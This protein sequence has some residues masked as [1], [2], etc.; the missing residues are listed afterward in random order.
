MFARIKH[1]TQRVVD[2]C[3]LCLLLTG[4]IV[5]A[6]DNSYGSR[7]H[8]RDGVYV[9]AEDDGYRT[10]LYKDRRYGYRPEYLDPVYR[11]PTRAPEDRY[12]FDVSQKIIAA[13]KKLFIELKFIHRIGIKIFIYIN[14]SVNFILSFK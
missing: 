5:F 3:C 10:Y 6:Q 13:Y 7:Y 12:L 14:K 4:V 2:C 11:G 8:G 9:P 1:A